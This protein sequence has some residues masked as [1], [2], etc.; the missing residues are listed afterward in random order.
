MPDISGYA[1]AFDNSS[2]RAGSRYHVLESTYDPV[3]RARLT[4]LGVA[5]GMRCLEVGGGGGSVAAWLAERVGPEGS[6]LATD[7]QPRW[8]GGHAD[9]ANLRVVRH[10]ITREELP[11]GHFDLVHA[12]LVLLHLPERRAALER[13]VRALRPGGRLVLDEFD[14]DWAPVLAAPSPQAAALFERMHAA[15]KG[16]LARAGA[17]PR[18]G[19]H[20]YEALRAAGLTDVACATWA[21][22][23]PGGSTGIRLHEVNIRDL[24]ERLTEDGLTH[25]DLDRCVR[26]LRDPAFVVNSY[27]LITTW[28]RRP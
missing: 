23:W 24:R 13:M 12:R 22:A 18:W 19:L 16:I 26:L 27:P 3:T 11:E 5:P 8:L 9:H 1:Y 4:E 6:V 15:V 17:D 25:D 28:G 20:A 21:E 14:C 10:D 2:E 7:I